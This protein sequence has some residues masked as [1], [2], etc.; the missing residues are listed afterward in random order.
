M[1]LVLLALTLTAFV[2]GAPDPGASAWERQAPAPGTQAAPSGAITGVVRNEAG[3]PIAGATVSINPSPA[4]QMTDDRGRFAFVRL[5]AGTYRITVNALGYVDGQYGQASAFA[6]PGTIALADG[7]WFDRA[8]V[9][10]S[11]TGGISGRVLDEHGEPVA[12]TYV[13]VLA[14]HHV[15]GSSRLFA[16][17]ATLTDDRGIYRIGRLPPA[18]YLV[19]VPSVQSTVP[20]D[21]Q[22]GDGRW[23]GRGFDGVSIR[24]RDAIP[25]EARL[26]ET[27]ADPANRVVLGSYAIA[28]PRSDGRPAVYPITFHP[29][30]SVPTAAAMIDLGPSEERSGIDVVLRTVP[31][32][33]V[34]GVASSLSGAAG[35]LTGVVLRLMP[36]GLEGLGTGSEAASTIIGADGRFTFLNVPAGHYVIDAG[37][38]T[39]L[40]FHSRTGV[41]LPLAAGVVNPN[42]QS[43]DVAGLAGGRYYSRAAVEPNRYFGRLPITVGPSD[44][45]VELPLHASVSLTGR[46]VFEGKGALALLSFT[47]G[48]AGNAAAAAALSLDTAL[49]IPPITAEPADGDTSLGVTE[50]GIIQTTDPASASFTIAGLRHGAYVL[51]M[52]NRT[53]RATIK[54][55]TVGGQD[56]THRPIDTTA[57]PPGPLGH[58]VVVT[59]TD[60]LP[61]IAGILRTTGATPLAAVIA[62]PVERDQW[63]RYGLTPTRIKSMAIDPNGGFRLRGLPA[64]EYFVVAVD[65]SQVNA[66]N[67]AAF[68]ERAAAVGARVTI[69]W[70]ETAQVTLTSLLKKPASSTANFKGRTS[71]A[72]TWRDSTVRSSEFTVLSSGDCDSQQSPGSPRTGSI[73]GVVREAGPDQR[74]VRGALILLTIAGTVN[75]QSA[76]SDEQGRFLIERVPAGQFSVTATKPAYLQ[77]AYGAPTPGRA[78]VPIVLAAGQHLT[79]V[80]LTMARGAAIAGSVRLPNGEPAPDTEV[81]VYRVPP[82]GGERTLVET[83]NVV[84]DDRGAYRAYGLMP[85]E[86]VVAALLSSGRTS[87]VAAIATAEMDR[88]LESLRRRTN[89]TATS[90]G[91]EPTAVPVSSGSYTTAPVFHPGVTSPA[92][93]GV[94]KVAAGDERTGIDFALRYSRT[95]SVEGTIRQVDGSAPPVQMAIIT[96][97]L[98]LP[99]MD[100]APPRN[101]ESKSTA[102]GAFK[103]TNFVPGRYVIAARTP[104]APWSYALVELDVAA[105][106][107]RGL[108]LTLQPAMRLSG[109]VAFDRTTLSAPADLSRV[110]LQLSNVDGGQGV[111][112]YTRV[113]NFRIDPA[114]VTADGRFEF[115]GILPGRYRLT[116]TVP[117]ETGWWARSA[118]AGGRDLFDGDVVITAGRDLTDV[119]L[120]FADRRTEISGTLQTATGGP[121][122]GLFIVAIPVDRSLWQPSSRRMRSTRSGTDSRWTIR[123]LPPG[124]YLVGAFSDVSDDDLHD[125]TFLEVLAAAAVRVTVG[126]GASVRLDLRIGGR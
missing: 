59:M 4:R 22:W 1:R 89:A 67:D 25:V 122:A 9:T 76:A 8:D 54:S 37:A 16:G 13:R 115:S 63:R 96:G 110:S 120:T 86:Y 105:D 83:L 95:V 94:I 26:H 123:D 17:P 56:F 30:G 68:L 24:R 87:D 62:F 69:G 125:R 61:E 90:A 38:K 104:S 50:T 81:T 45:V 74:P 40:S 23:S 106:D 52:H 28:P 35:P 48:A 108:P 7:Q 33:R 6:L 118:I 42:S 85:G 15:A 20:V 80:T 12:G 55:I 73:A 3:Q 53:D 57:L 65:L 21:H 109:R 99:T 49:V 116:A 36:V 70:G 60:E 18:R 32:V 124:D 101:S 72:G 71:N 126:D 14:Q 107:V 84:T 64:G 88:V 46:L 97:G 82:G 113:G 44:L 5:P 75:G 114:A 119:V 31:A 79:N 117:G 41:S 11:R 93:A 78:G 29:G 102:T 77:G 2:A 10:L 51:R 27:A 19:V 58:E 111:F 66:W 47:A 43:G 92:D 34:S 91:R 100:S 103:Y 39:E 98:R 112:G 121:V